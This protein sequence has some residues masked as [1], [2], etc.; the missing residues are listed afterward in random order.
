MYQLICIWNAL[1]SGQQRTSCILL[2][3]SFLDKHVSNQQYR[4]IS[5]NDNIIRVLHVCS[6]HEQS[7]IA[8]MCLSMGILPCILDTNFGT[9][10]HNEPTRCFKDIKVLWHYNLMHYKHFSCFGCLKH[11]ERR[12]HN[13]RTVNHTTSQ[14]F[15][16]ELSPGL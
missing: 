7:N 13:R 8:I 9:F 14:S 12:I 15:S 2:W 16:N 3:S 6:C 11:F 1:T 5:F 10:R 4:H